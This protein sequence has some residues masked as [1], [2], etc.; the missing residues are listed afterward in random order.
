MENDEIE[1]GNLKIAEKAKN[2]IFG[3]SFLSFVFCYDEL[4]FFSPGLWSGCRDFIQQAVYRFFGISG[5]NL[6]AVVYRGRISGFFV[7]G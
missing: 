2:I 4:F 3:K 1:S 7:R 5:G 6:G